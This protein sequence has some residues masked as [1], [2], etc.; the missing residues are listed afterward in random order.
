MEVLIKDKCFL[1]NLINQKVKTFNKINKIIKTKDVVME[2][3]NGLM[4]Q[5][6]RVNG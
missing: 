5:F 6:M 3:K 2:Y 1:P 4:V